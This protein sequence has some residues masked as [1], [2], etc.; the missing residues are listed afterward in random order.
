MNEDLLHFIWKFKLLK[1]KNLF[2]IGEMPIS[3]VHRGEHNSHAGPDFANARIKLGDT[4]WA[5]NIEIHKRSS[6]WF[7]HNHHTDRAYDNVILHVVYEYNCEIYNSKKQLIPCLELK[8]FIEED[9]L[10]RYE[11]LYK[12]KQIIPCG[13][14]FADVPDIIREPW[15]ERMLIERL[16]VK[17]QFIA[18]IFNFTNRNWDETLYL[19]LCKN[20]GFKT[21][22]DA[23]LQLG[24]AV[25]LNILL[26]HAS[27]IE[28][29]EALL[30]GQSG[31]LDNDHKDTYIRRLQAEYAHL[32]R[33][34]Q[35]PAPVPHNWKF[36][37]MRP[38]NFPT[39]RIAQLAGFISTYQHTF[40]KIIEAASVKEVKKLFQ[41]HT[42]PYWENHYVFDER[43]IPEEKKLGNS[44][45]ENILIN[46][47]CP[48]LFFYGKA[49]MEESLCQ[50]ALE[51]L[52]GLKPESN[53]IT[54][55][56]EEISFIPASAGQS[57]SLLQ[58]HTNYCTGKK[59]LRC[60]IGTHL[61][62]AKQAV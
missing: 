12:N 41:T 10:K 13:K 33:K 1:P 4:E 7:V 48:L 56:F 20:L 50:K 14:Q 2:S 38:R 18:D 62:K 32:K 28:Q 3:I 5:G 57:Q 51:W 25:P 35:L 8:N 61:L 11:H 30:F 42:S 44:S 16:E 49:R 31:L 27:F 54:K 39:V 23:F 45:I 43:S 22:G 17:T 26:K 59:C 36:L 37:R 55:Q 9:L 53:H 46:T 21:N 58:L 60:G 34:Y 6:D 19:L 15:L 24:K 47:V 29:T 52:T 40:S